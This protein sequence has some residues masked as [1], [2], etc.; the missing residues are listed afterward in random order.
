MIM[1]FEPIGHYR[2]TKKL[3]EGGMG[4]VYAAHDEQ[5]DRNVVVK[6]IRDVGH[7]ATSRDRFWRERRQPSVTPTCASSTRSAS[8]TEPCSS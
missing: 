2:I 5:L 8:P 6:M 3:G 4:V 1:T 7:D